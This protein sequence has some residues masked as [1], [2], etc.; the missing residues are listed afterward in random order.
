MSSKLI[1]EAL[2]TQPKKK[3]KTMSQ[4]ESQPVAEQSGF[5]AYFRKGDPIEN[6]RKD[7][8]KIL[9]KHPD[10]KFDENDDE[11]NQFVSSLDAQQLRKYIDEAKEMVGTKDEY[12]NSKSALAM[13]GRLLDRLCGKSGIGKSM[14]GDDE[15]VKMVEEY[16]PS[17]I[18]WM[19]TPF[20]IIDRVI[21]HVQETK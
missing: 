6:L 8:K 18:E 19:S 4:A 17:D 3:G 16:I 10:L 12:S 13:L 1:D 21:S 9:K 14:I 7:L 15:L 11:I 20:Q 5:L 2:S